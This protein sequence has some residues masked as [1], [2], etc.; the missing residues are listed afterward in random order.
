MLP[1]PTPAPPTPSADQ[2]YQAG[3]L[4]GVVGVSSSTCPRTLPGVQAVLE[5]MVREQQY[6]QAVQATGGGTWLKVRG[7]EVHKGLPSGALYRFPDTGCTTWQAST[8][9]AIWVRPNHR[10]L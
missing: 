1:S 6:R 10:F 9:H 5:L 3:W 7:S 4:L 8:S 2:L